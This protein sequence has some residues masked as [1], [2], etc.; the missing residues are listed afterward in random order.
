MAGTCLAVVPLLKAVRPR[1]KPNL[2][3]SP[4]EDSL[5]AA[6]PRTAALH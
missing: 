1:Y 2:S 3:G 4:I 5:D 6:N